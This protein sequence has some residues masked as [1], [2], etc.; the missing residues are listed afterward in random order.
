[1]ERERRLLMG[2]DRR[3]LMRRWFEEI[4]NQGRYE[5]VDELFHQDAIAHGLREGE[6]PLHGPEEL[7]AFQLAFRAGFPDIHIDIDDLVVEDEKVA[8]RFTARATHRGEFF[9]VPATGRRINVSGMCLV[10]VRDGQMIEAW[11]QYDLFGL[12]RQIGAIP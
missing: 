10:R 12:L 9:G 6:Q 3:A 4:W 8:V 7:K 5:V 2:D 1:M 11:N